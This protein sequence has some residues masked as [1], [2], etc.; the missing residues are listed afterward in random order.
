MTDIKLQSVHR[1]VFDHTQDGKDDVRP[2][3]DI[4]CFTKES[5]DLVPG[6][7]VKAGDSMVREEDVRQLKDVLRF[8]VQR[9]SEAGREDDPKHREEVSNV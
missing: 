1:T 5:R 8:F 7:K 4:L 9:T 2:L 3:S 6:N